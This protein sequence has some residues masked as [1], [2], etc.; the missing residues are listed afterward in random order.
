MFE[1]DLLLY[2]LMKI[3]QILENFTPYEWEVGS[4]AWE[5]A[6]NFVSEKFWGVVNLVL[7]AWIDE[8]RKWY[9]L[10]WYRV[11]FLPTVKIGSRRF[12]KFWSK[13]YR[14]CFKRIKDWNPDTIHTHS[15][16]FLVSMLW[17]CCSIKWNK[18][19]VFFEHSAWRRTV[20]WWWKSFQRKVYNRTFWKISLIFC[21]DIVT[22]NQLS[23]NYLKKFTNKRLNLI[24]RW[25]DIPI[26][27]KVVRN[28]FVIRM[29]FI[30][31]IVKLSGIWTLFKAYVEIVKSH[32]NVMLDIIWDGDEKLELE[33]LIVKFWLS[34]WMKTL[35]KISKDDIWTKYLPTYDIVIN[36][37]LDNEE[38][39]SETTLWGLLAKCIVISSDIWAVREITNMEDLIIVPAGDVN[40]L[41]KAIE[42]ALWKLDKSWM[43]FDVVKEKFSW[44]NSIKKYLE[45]CYP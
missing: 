25:C 44:K 15:R 4:Y 3:V 23:Y 28:D 38:L 14:D 34:N 24:Y 7:F 18:K 35:W 5:F 17:L 11:I 13:E 22:L 42:H 29:C 27:K 31:N 8:T 21:N 20:L 12:L 40:A 36:P 43:S 19:W 37:T 10:D 39:I 2:L 30:S 16:S 6:K 9:D 1:F 26:V 41:V 33:N 32:P 45:V